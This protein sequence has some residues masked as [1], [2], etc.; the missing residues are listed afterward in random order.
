MFLL[1]FSFSF[2]L[3]LFEKV[4]GKG[5]THKGHREKVLKVVHFRDFSGCFRGIFRELQGISGCFQGCFSL[6]PFRVCPLDPSNLFLSLSLYLCI[7]H[8][9]IVG[10]GKAFRHGGHVGAWLLHDLLTQN[11]S[12]QLQSS[13]HLIICPSQSAEACR[14]FFVVQILE[15][16]LGD[17]PGGFFWALFLTKMRRKNPASKSAKKSGGPKQKKSAK[18]PFCQN[19]TLKLNKK[20]GDH[21]PFF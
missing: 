11:G 8:H 12:S 9:L 7:W 14:R 13:C 16:F 15:D 17:F 1:S 21:P 4:E 5:H 20:P 2:S 3:S 10:H 18:N 19:P 6:C